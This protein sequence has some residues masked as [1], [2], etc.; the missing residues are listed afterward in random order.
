MLPEGEER[1]FQRPRRRACYA[2]SVPP[3]TTLGALIQSLALQANEEYFVCAW[4]LDEAS[5]APLLLLAGK[6]GLL[7]AVN[8]LTGTLE[9]RPRVA[10]VHN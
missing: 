5:G 1:T 10:A 2:A 6:K 8:A 3:A 4:S 7:L 9:V